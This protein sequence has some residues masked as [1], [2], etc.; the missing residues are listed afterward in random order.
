MSFCETQNDFINKLS[1]IF[2]QLALFFGGKREF[3]F[4]LFC[5]TF[6]IKEINN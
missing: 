2:F 1:V 3:C 5:F 6:I 4:V